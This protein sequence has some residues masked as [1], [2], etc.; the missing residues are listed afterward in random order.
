MNTIDGPQKNVV[1]KNDACVN[2]HVVLYFHIVANNALRRD[3]DVLADVAVLADTAFLHN[4]AEVPDPRASTDAAR[5]VDVRRFMHE[6]VVFRYHIPIPVSGRDFAILAL[7]ACTS[8]ELAPVF[9]H[10]RIYRLD[11]GV[12]VQGIIHELSRIVDIEIGV[13]CSCLGDQS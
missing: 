11:N 10:E 6:E 7:V 12:V 3:Y 4:M 8:L 1:L 5:F 9:L 13:S 2:G